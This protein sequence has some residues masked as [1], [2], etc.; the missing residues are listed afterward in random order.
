[1]DSIGY[2]LSEV[3]VLFFVIWFAFRLVQY[4]RYR[5]NQ[6]IYSDKDRQLLFSR[7]NTTLEPPVFRLGLARAILA[8]TA[9]TYFEILTLAPF[10]AAILSTALVLTN[11]AIVRWFL[12]FDT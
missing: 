9:A 7:A 2:V 5:R 12:V 11:A 1:M 4:R 6:P 8:A 3:P 10:G